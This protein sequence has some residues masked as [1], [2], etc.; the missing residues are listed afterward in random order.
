MVSG[1]LTAPDRGSGASASRLG[2]M[3]PTRCVLDSLRTR[4]FWA[5]SPVAQR[6][7]ANS[8]AVRRALGEVSA[9]AGLTR[10][11]TSP[12]SLVT[13][14]SS[15]RMAGAGSA[16]LRVGFAR[17]K[18]STSSLSG[19]QPNWLEPSHDL[20]LCFGPRHSDKSGEPVSEGGSVKKAK[21]KLGDVDAGE[22]AARPRIPLDAAVQ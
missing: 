3:V 15:A 10:P 4:S 16:P 1:A 11:G 20:R 18:G 13:V 17:V 14:V 5:A 6:A 8:R 9:D 19:R 7:T 12:S 2:W 22:T 21:R